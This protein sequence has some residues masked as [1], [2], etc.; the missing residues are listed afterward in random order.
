MLSTLAFSLSTF[1]MFS[2][3]YVGIAL[4]RIAKEELKAGKYFLITLKNVLLVLIWLA[5]L[6]GASFSMLSLVASG[7]FLLLILLR[8]K[9]RWNLDSGIIDYFFFSL[10]TFFISAGKNSFF[11]AA[12]LIFVYGFPAGS[13]MRI[14]P[15]MRAMLIAPF[16]YIHF[17]II[18]NI[19]FLSIAYTF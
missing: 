18:A 5:F 4:S 10:I 19:L 6:I 3:I 7:A 2:G 15:G 17:P 9:L 1:L 14:K 11:I 12:A 13:L 16:R 8:W